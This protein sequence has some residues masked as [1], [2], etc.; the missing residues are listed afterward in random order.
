VVRRT[1]PTNASLDIKQLK[2]IIQAH[3]LF[4]QDIATDGSKPDQGGLIK[5][6]NKKG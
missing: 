1:P 6:F 2:Q 4:G 3:L 5:E